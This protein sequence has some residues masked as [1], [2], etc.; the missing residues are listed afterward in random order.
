VV[1]GFP[2]VCEWLLE[3]GA[4]PVMYDVSGRNC[5]Y[6][7]IEFGHLA[8]VTAILDR[9]GVSASQVLARA[10]CILTQASG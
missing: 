10:I 6:V 8:L 4:D 1:C 7:A 2:E 3:R 9:F 5:L